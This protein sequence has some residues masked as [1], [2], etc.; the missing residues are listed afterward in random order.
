MLR[1]FS[2][3]M[4]SRMREKKLLMPNSVFPNV[5]KM[6]KKNVIRMD[7]QSVSMSP[8]QEFA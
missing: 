8:P 1:N 6:V 2:T 3:L 7:I 5:K 4:S